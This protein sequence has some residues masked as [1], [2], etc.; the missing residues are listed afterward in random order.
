[1]GDV[2]DFRTFMGAVIDRK[3]LERISGYLDDARRNA[4]I[5]QGAGAHDDTRLLRGADAG[6]DAR[7]RPTG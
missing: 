7:S 3:A 2:A 6:R 4:S 5:L 1:M